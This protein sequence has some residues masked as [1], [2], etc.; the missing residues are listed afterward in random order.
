MNC[1]IFQRSRVW[2]TL[3]LI[4]TIFLAFGV[5][6]R[7]SAEVATWPYE[8]AYIHYIVLTPPN[9]QVNR[10]Q[11][12]DFD[13]YTFFQNG[14]PILHAY[15]GN[16]PNFPLL[17][18]EHVFSKNR[19]PIN[20]LNAKTILYQHTS[21]GSSKEILVTLR[22]VSNT[23]CR[24]VHFYYHNDSRSEAALADSIIGSLE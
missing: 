6:S 23:C 2:A 15:V 22:L 11:K 21:D 9:M 17:S 4:L 14:R 16:N 3:Y 12:A 10:A 13:L 8:F 18:N 20:E 24:Y 5:P 19:D 7:A 1:T